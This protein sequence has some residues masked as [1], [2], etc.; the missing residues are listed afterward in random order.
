MRAHMALKYSGIKV[1]L[2]EVDLKNYPPQALEISPKATVPVLLLP[3][4]TVI[5]ESWDILKW[6][7]SQ[8][9]PDNWNGDND[10]HTLDARF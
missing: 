8:N 1:E 3:D 10:E 9:D 7:L 4:G 6:A 5:D 2:R